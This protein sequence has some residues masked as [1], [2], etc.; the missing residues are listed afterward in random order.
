MFTQLV[1]GKQR[2]ELLEPLG[3]G[4]SFLT[5]FL[6]KWGEGLH[7]LTFQVDNVEKASDYLRAKGL[8][9]TDEFYEESTVEDSVHFSEEHFRRANTT[10]RNYSRKQIRPFLVS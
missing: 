5:K 2:I 7:H 6:A 10:L 1:L 8:K 3:N 4:E 9:I